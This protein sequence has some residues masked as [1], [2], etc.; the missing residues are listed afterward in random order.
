MITQSIHLATQMPF[1][2]C[3]AINNFPGSWYCTVASSNIQKPSLKFLRQAVGSWRKN[4]EKSAKLPSV[5]D[6][7]SVDTI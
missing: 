6:N 7:F 3:K 1:L 2:K 5:G 4:G